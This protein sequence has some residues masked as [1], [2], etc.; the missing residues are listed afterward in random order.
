MSPAE[1]G[2]REEEVLWGGS[3]VGPRV[4]QAK[5]SRTSSKFAVPGPSSLPWHPGDLSNP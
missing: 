1:K 2:S 4:S 5:G 3:G